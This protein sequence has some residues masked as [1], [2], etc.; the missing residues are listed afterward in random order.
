[1]RSA[2]C[3]RPSPTGAL[4]TAL[5]RKN[6][7][8]L[9]DSVAIQRKAVGAE[10]LSWFAQ[11]ESARASVDSQACHKA[12]CQSSEPALVTATMEIPTIDDPS[13]NNDARRQIQHVARQV[14][15]AFDRSGAAAREVTNA[16]GQWCLCALTGQGGVGSGSTRPGRGGKRGGNAMESFIVCVDLVRR[17]R[18]TSSVSGR[19]S[20]SRGCTQGCGSSGVIC[21]RPLA[22]GLLPD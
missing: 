17:H 21:H 4:V 12:E 1:L 11:H 18:R 5:A 6:L 19:A 10:E 20:I 16:P 7:R 3:R 9:F 2:S 22:S 13:V 14:I 8:L 15:R